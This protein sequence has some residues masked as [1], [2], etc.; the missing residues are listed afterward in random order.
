M[1]WNGK[2][3]KRDRKWR[4]RWRRRAIHEFERD[5]NEAIGGKGKRRV[6][7]EI[8]F[9]EIAWSSVRFFEPAAPITAEMMQRAIDLVPVMHMRVE[10][11]SRPHAVISGY[12]WNTKPSKEWDE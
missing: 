9:D 3:T 5:A 2:T 10:L 8:P 7:W 4:S 11:N 6:E 1:G 12:D